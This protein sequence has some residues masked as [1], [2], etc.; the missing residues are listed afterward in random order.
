MSKRLLWVAVSMGI[1][2]FVSM[3][4]R[5]SA[6]IKKEL[7]QLP[8]SLCA[9]SYFSPT[10]I[11]DSAE[12][13][14]W[15]TCVPDFFAAPEGLNSGNILTLQN[16]KSMV[17]MKSGDV[18]YSYHLNEDGIIFRSRYLN[19]LE[20]S[21]SLI[22]RVTK[23]QN[24][25]ALFA[26]KDDDG[27]DHL[28]VISGDNKTNSMLT[29][30]DFDRGVQILPTD[31]VYLGTYAEMNGPKHLFIAKDRD[32]WFGFTFDKND[33]LV[34][35]RFTDGILRAPYA[36]IMGNIDQKFNGVSSL[37]G[38][39]ELGN[40]HLF[41]TN[42]TGS[43]VQRLTFGNSLNNTP[44]VVELGDFN[45]QINQPVGLTITK[46][47]DAYYAFVLNYQT[48]SLVTLKWDQQSIA[49][50]PIYINHGNV[51]N[52]EQPRFLTNIQPE[53]G[54]LYFFGINKDSTLSKFIYRPC[55]TDMVTYAPSS[56][57]IPYFAYNEPGTY[58]ISLTINQGMANVDVYCK[59]ITIFAHPPITLSNDTLICQGDKIELKAQSFGHDSIIWN[60]KYNMEAMDTTRGELIHVWP[61]FTSKYV[62]TTYF[63]TNCI[64]PDTITVM[65]SRIKADAGPD[66]VIGDG[67]YTV[68]G[69]AETTTGGG[70][71]YRWTPEIGI[72]QSTGTP[73]TE[74]R[75]PYNITYYLRV[76]ND[77]GCRAIDSVSVRVPCND[78]NLPNAFIPGSPNGKVNRFGL[79]N[80]QFAKI[81]YFKIYDRWGKEV[82]STTDPSAGWDGTVDGKP[83]PLGV[84]VWEVDA[85]CANT[86][87]RFRKAGNVTL[88]R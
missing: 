74:A 52:I 59:E 43:N 40:W 67:S 24:A 5:V 9:G 14:T 33:N 49:N 16:A 80:Q 41:I 26:L 35:L 82:F 56:G 39:Q 17:F 68:L 19:G 31:S 44:Y 38:L 60:T 27:K 85:N 77:D 25:S 75:P 8:D 50:Q 18:Y 13:Y 32:N 15:S 1:F 42:R 87:E 76:T 78:V 66:R 79:L 4:E 28:F 11:Y 47:C 71:T 20:G 45:H 55:D 6:Q 83:A 88:I 81:N 64:V 72:T 7:F 22:T 73:I 69:G 10:E 61:D 29:R 58:T 36:E 48:K 63:D 12:T 37:T 84:Y 70:Y 57:D 54:N 2:L 51:A 62:V 23:M 21:P 65:V 34:R 46:S 3:P 53:N 30:F 86:L